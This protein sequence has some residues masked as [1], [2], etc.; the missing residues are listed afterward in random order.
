MISLS[1]SA[2][3]I[4]HIKESVDSSPRVY[5]QI[6]KGDDDHSTFHC[7]S[8]SMVVRMRLYSK[9]KNQRGTGKI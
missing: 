2:V 9:D 4:V 3:F 5:A 8:S 6:V 7:D 1:F